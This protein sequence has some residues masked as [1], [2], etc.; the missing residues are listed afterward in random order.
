MKDTDWSGSVLLFWTS[1]VDSGSLRYL[2]DTPA[3]PS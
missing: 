1:D 3:V 2:E